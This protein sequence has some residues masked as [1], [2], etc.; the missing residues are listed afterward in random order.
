MVN[1]PSTDD[2]LEVLRPWREHIRYFDNPERNLSVSRNIGLRA[3]N[4]ELIAFI[5][6]DALP[7]PEWL[8]Q[9]IPAFDDPEVAGAGGIVFDHTGMALQYR[10]AATNRLLQTVAERPRLR[11]AVLPRDV[12]VPVPPGHEPDLP[13]QAP[14]RRR[15]L[16]RADLLLRRRLR[17]LRPAHRRRLGDPPAGDVARAPQ[18]PAVRYPRSPA[19]HDELVPGRPRPHLLL[20]ASWIAVHDRGRDP[21]HR[22][23]LHGHQGRRHEMA[24][25]GRPPARRIGPLGQSDML[26]GI[27]PGTSGGSRVRRTDV[28]ADR[29][30]TGPVPAVPDDHATP[31]TASWCSCRTAT[32]GTSRAALPACSA[33]SRRRWRPAATTC[34]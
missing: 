2:T 20:L 3:T 14:A 31:T 7:E 1:G 10:Y 16:R 28:A 30:G 24:R 13:A 27:R 11:V 8:A 6:D 21:E 29:A 22:P 26:V 9:A 32:P 34:G 4:G 18:V 19:H 15:R 23:G 17:H 25:G 33:T 12:P 5:D